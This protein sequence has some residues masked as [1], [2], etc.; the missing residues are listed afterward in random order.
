LLGSL[1]YFERTTKF[2]LVN[3]IKFYENL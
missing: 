3:K 1:D 2:D